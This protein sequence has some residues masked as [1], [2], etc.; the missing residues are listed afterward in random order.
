MGRGD[1]CAVVPFAY[2]VSWIIGCPHTHINVRNLMMLLLLLL[3]AMLSQGD[4]GMP[5]VVS[6]GVG[7]N[8]WRIVNIL[9]RIC[10]YQEHTKTENE[11]VCRFFVF[12]FE[13]Y[14]LFQL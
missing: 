6:H 10:I 9:N 8:E 12:H 2:L 5:H 1:L 7:S 14:F 3:M 13:L 11:N 4:I